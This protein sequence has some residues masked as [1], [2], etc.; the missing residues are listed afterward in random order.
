MALVTDLIGGAGYDYATID[1]WDSGT[2]GDLVDAAAF[3]LGMRC[4]L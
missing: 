3:R 1:G 2:E 4:D